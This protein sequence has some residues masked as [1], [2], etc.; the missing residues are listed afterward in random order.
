LLPPLLLLCVV[1]FGVSLCAFLILVLQDF[2]VD[3]HVY[4]KKAYMQQI[5]LIMFNRI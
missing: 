5:N 2:L 3:V 1:L 4:A